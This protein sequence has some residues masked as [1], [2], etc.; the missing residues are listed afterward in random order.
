MVAALEFALN[1]PTGEDDSYWNTDVGRPFAVQH[2]PMVPH[3][4]TEDAPPKLNPAQT[5]HL[6]HSAQHADKL[7]TEIESILNAGDAKSPF[8]KFKSGLSSAQARVIADYIAR[9]RMQL[10]RVL[11][12]LGVGLPEPELESVHAMRVTL[13]FVRIAFQECTPDRM[14]GYGPVPESRIRELSGLVDEMVAAAD[15]LD[16]YLAAGLGEDLE[17]RLARL[18]AA[19]ADVRTLKTLERIVSDHGFVEFRPSLSMIADRV[20]GNRFEVALFGRVS[21][22]K[23]SLL[24]HFVGSEILPVGVNPITA[25]PTR[26]SYGP[27]RLT[28]WYADRRPE[29]M[30]ISRLAE[31]VSE[32]H[33]SGNHKRVTRILAEL[34][35]PRLK[36]GVVLVDTPGLG[37]LA[38]SGAAETLAYL[39]RCDLG[40]VLI[41]AG[42]TLTLDDL[43]T[44][45]T[46]YEAGIPAS[47]LLSKSDLVD[48]ADR[49]R[50]AQYIA[51][52]ISKQLGLHIAVYPVS[53][54]ATHAA[55]LEQWVRQVIEPLF[56]NHVRLMRES[57]ARKTGLLCDGVRTALEV[58]LGR[59]GSRPVASQDGSVDRELRSAAG[60]I[61]EVR[62]AC[63]AMTQQLRSAG[64][65][66]LTLSANRLT[67]AWGRTGSSPA[68]VVKQA[69]EMVAAERANAIFLALRD[70]ASDVAQTVESAAD[71][72]AFE[73]TNAAEDLVSAVRELPK[74]DLGE[75]D[76][77]VKPGL[78]RKFSRELSNRKTAHA[79]R[80]E[81]GEQVSR[82]FS[83][84]G[85]VV[86]A[87]VRRTLSDLQLRFE[88]QADTY[89][90]HLDRVGGAPR[91]SGE[92]RSAM[93]R[94][95]EAL[96]QT[97]GIAESG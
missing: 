61:A 77:R 84:F 92:E 9:I 26:L 66:A 39:P 36:E 35:S 33:N 48:E 96:S 10:I 30:E 85:S 34:P 72:L 4:G 15:K 32:H 17:A 24:N 68:D 53:V 65:E 2:R 52:E 67:D 21:T 49:D 42:S 47:V 54:R 69:I 73:K 16:S 18:A 8:R 5:A 64:D 11:A 70:L 29:Q 97:C 82:A 91:L 58:R 28:V 38:A 6:L 40:V 46:L 62:D 50:S 25:I 14:Q 79:L 31:F 93:E 63:L 23:S 55:L 19:G 71:S 45:R 37:S 56:E 3:V 83:D 12:A 1:R 94:D 7:L 44:I 87:W 88:S 81:I 60:K 51:G 80:G 57:L 13:A 41:D 78:T 75:F 89:R 22:G 43:A 74:L 27:A 76:L 59:V 86:D 95:L 90:A 20:E